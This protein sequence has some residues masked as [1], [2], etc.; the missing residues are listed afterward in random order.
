[1]GTQI[2]Y[3]VAKSLSESS[4][5]PYNI[6]KVEYMHRLNMVAGIKGPQKELVRAGKDTRPSGL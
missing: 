1:M 6:V 3:P 5:I 4:Y 2:F